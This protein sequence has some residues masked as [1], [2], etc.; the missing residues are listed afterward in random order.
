MIKIKII[1]K[2]PKILNTKINKRISEYTFRNLGIPSNLIDFSSNDY[3]GFA[4]DSNIFERA[5]QLLLDK[6]IVE[7]GGTGSRLLSGNHPLYTE[8]ETQ[9]CKVHHCEAA[10]VFNS[11]YTANLGFFSSVPQRGDI[12][13][14]DEL[15]H[16]SIRDGLKMSQ[17]KSYKFKHNDLEDL[18]E[19]LKKLNIEE[20]QSVY[21]VTESVF[22]MDGDSPDLLKLT[23]IC[24]E[25]KALLI[26]DEAH[27]LGVFGYGL[28][29]EL[30]IENDCF[31][32]IVTFGKTIGVHGAAILGSQD[33]I[34]YLINFSRP[35]I[36]T[37]SMPPHTLASLIV[38]YDE[39]NV[40]KNMQ[41]LKQNISHF[42]SNIDSLDF[43]PS[44]SAIQCCIISGNERAKSVAN[45]LAYKGYDVKP[46]LS[47][48]VPEGYERLRFCLHAFNSKEDITKVLS[49]LKT[50]IYE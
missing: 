48:T 28:M 21:V 38:V 4:R 27:A 33:L 13:F 44:N 36:Y 47:P 40:T 3:L 23:E 5:H 41:I 18:T 12:I 35:F 45:Q 34:N 1:L 26:V 24:K 15:A 30:N 39:L 29:Q 2:L 49:E 9:L 20:I 16:A 46:I 8:F 37:T 10:L 31:A 50:M 17:A 19:K 6:N 43:I 11:G 42:Q 22:S 32:R 14:Y 25:F 7:N